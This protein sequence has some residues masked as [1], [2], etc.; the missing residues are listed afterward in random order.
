MQM[1]CFYG[2]QPALQYY[3]QPGIPIKYKCTYQRSIQVFFCFVLYIFI[4]YTPARDFTFSSTCHLRDVFHISSVE[5]LPE[6][7]TI[8]DYTCSLYT[9]IFSKHISKQLALSLH[10]REIEDVSNLQHKIYKTLEYTSTI[11]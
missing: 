9:W 3:Q 10:V 8:L 7:H 6:H 1:D 11:T 4:P 5:S 2:N